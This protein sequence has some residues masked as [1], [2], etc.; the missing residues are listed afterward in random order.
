MIARDY[1]HERAFEGT[2]AYHPRIINTILFPSLSLATGMACAA[3][4]RAASCGTSCL[5]ESIVMFLHIPEG[6][7]QIN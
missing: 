7:K 3:A 1:L 5:I 6:R 2:S 4:R